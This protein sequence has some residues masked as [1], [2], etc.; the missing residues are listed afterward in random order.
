MRRYQR[1]LVYQLPAILYM[2]FIFYLSSGPVTIDI[3]NSIPDYY[4]HTAEYA[5]LCVLLF[6]AIHEGLAPKA[7]RG[8]AWLPAVFTILYGISDEYHQSFVPQR[9]AS[10]HDVLS[11]TIGAALGI[12]IVVALRRLW[13]RYCEKVTLQSSSREQGA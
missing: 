12:L 9:E 3:L 5:A 6:W 2:I 4:L 11:D 10:L 7:A 8:S 13:N 1:F